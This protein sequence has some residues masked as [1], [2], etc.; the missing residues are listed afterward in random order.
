MQRQKTPHEILGVGADASEADIS[1]AY[2]KLRIA[3]SPDHSSEYNNLSI[4]LNHLEKR[5]IRA[6]PDEQADIRAEIMQKER[7]YKKL[8]DNLGRRMI[9]LENAYQYLTGKLKNQQKTLVEQFST[10][11]KEDQE[12]YIFRMI[13]NYNQLLR[14]GAELPLNDEYHN[15]LRDQSPESLDL[16]KRQ[17]IKELQASKERQNSQMII[18]HINRIINALPQIRPSAPSSAKGKE[19]ADA[20][21]DVRAA[22]PEPSQKSNKIFHIQLGDINV[23]ADSL[24][25]GLKAFRAQIYGGDHRHTPMGHACGDIII[26]YENNAFYGRSVFNYQRK[27]VDNEMADVLEFK[28]GG[29]FLLN[30]N[31]EKAWRQAISEERAPAAHS[32]ERIDARHNY[33]LSQLNRDESQYFMLGLMQAA[34]ENNPILAGILNQQSLES[35][36]QLNRRNLF[37]SIPDRARTQQHNDALDRLLNLKHE[38]TT[39]RERLLAEFQA[40]NNDMEK[41]V[42][43]SKLKSGDPRVGQLDALHKEMLVIR[44][45]IEKGRFASLESVKQHIAPLIEKLLMCD[46]KKL[47]VFTDKDSLTHN[48]VAIMRKYNI[49]IQV[50]GK[51]EFRPQA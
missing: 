19:H 50:S 24:E 42:S 39:T 21:P 3:L 43:I 13:A 28:S 23:Y 41:A 51:H 26:T 8:A 20:A 37:Y 45:Q 7:E 40:F 12:D 33:N 17:F 29:N 32:H 27:K 4:E 48:L 1:K 5:R 16:F 18:D 30:D 2:R 46:K 49:N 11:K 44:Q 15:F 47:G 35:L 38:I 25:E 10:M 6:N 14:F 36:Q 22:N 9:E 31:F 34:M